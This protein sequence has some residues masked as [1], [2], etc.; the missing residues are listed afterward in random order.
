MKY[1]RLFNV[2]PLRLLTLY[3]FLFIVFQS[4][5]SQ[6]K[7]LETS[8]DVIFVAL[9]AIAFGTTF[10]KK[11]KEG[12]QQFVKSFLVNFTTTAA[13][14]ILIHKQRPNMENFN[15]FPSGHTSVSFQGASFIQRRYGWKYGLPAYVLAGFT[16]FT[17]INAD[18]HDFTDV[19][20]G[21]LLGIGSTYLFTTPYQ[22][23]HM[24]LSF[25]RFDNTYLIGFKF[26]F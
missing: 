7:T 16:G 18:K 11:D 13:L 21:A 5:S 15:A 6:N 2:M 17:R 19:F 9:P 20:A 25:N 4:V 26:K 3:F 24:E 23:E 22:Q 10:L 12:S 14:K 1:N 8:G